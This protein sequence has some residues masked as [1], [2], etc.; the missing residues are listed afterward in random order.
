M[1]SGRREGPMR[2]DSCGYPAYGSGANPS[3]GTWVGSSIQAA[4]LLEYRMGEFEFRS[5]EAVAAA[6]S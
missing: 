4:G 1:L 5:E 6:V 3:S 2:D